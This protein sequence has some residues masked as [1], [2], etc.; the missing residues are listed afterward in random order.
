MIP[1]ERSA[2]LLSGRLGMGHDVMA[3]AFADV[4]QERSWTTRI[5]DSMDLLGE[6]A[7]RAG[8]LTFRAMLAVP[9][10]YDALHFS[11]F[12][13]GGRVAQ[14]A[15]AAARGRTIPRL[16][17]LFQRERPDLV[18][19]VFATGASAAAVL[20]RRGNL[21]P[22][23][24]F[25]TDVTPH[26]LWVHE[27]VDA[28]LV[29]SGVAA[30]AIRRFQPRAKVFVTPPPVRTDFRR[31]PT[32]SHARNRFSI[33]LD[34][35]CVLLI[36]G[37]WGLGPLSR[38]AASLANDGI[39]VLA[40]AGRNARLH[41]RLTTLALSQPLVH[42]FGY[43]DE[44]PA[45]MTA[46]DLVVTTS[47]DTCA[48]ARAIGRDLL[49]LDVVPGHGRDNLQHE[50]ELGH[51][52]VTSA[53]PELVRAAVLSLLENRELRMPYDPLPEFAATVTRLLDGVGVPDAIME[54][55]VDGQRGWTS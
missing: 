19:G 43:T 27:G 45:L 15:D 25:C 12:R 9:A 53:D 20:A 51:A 36:S 14:A 11:A 42:V 10:G 37:S 22:L 1:S 33:P 2:L 23:V 44:I 47:G 4:L 26:R 35:S 30:A 8:T 54:N 3:E 39:H 46:S 50:L 41:R 16:Q 13:P 52:A 21:A 18:V 29:T 38:V 28:Y 5:V 55:A 49:L 34:A 31:P 6:R 17:E 40:V 32:R 48:E 7:G 24:V